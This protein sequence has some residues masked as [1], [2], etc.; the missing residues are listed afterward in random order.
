MNNTKIITNTLKKEEDGLSIT[1]LVDKTPL[2]RGQIR[3]ALAFL[4][5][6]ELINERQVGMTKLYYI[7][8][9]KRKLIVVLELQYLQ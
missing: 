5:G 8:K 2:S 4:L 7:K 3:T 1:E 9:W 6:A